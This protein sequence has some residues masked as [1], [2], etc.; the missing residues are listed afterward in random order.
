MAGLVEAEVFC[1]RS[2]DLVRAW[3]PHAFGYFLI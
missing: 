2:G 1:V 3:L